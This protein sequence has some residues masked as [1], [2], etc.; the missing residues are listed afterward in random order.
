VL[1]GGTPNGTPVASFTRAVFITGVCLTAGTGVALFAVPGRT[2]DYWA[3]TIKAPLSAAFFGAGYVGAA[4]AL[5]LAAGTRE[6]RRARIVT[7][8]AFTLTSLALLDTL[9]ETGPFAFGAG[10]VTEAV[11]WIWLVVYVV[12]PPLLLVAFVRQELAGG[13]REYGL[14]HPALAVSRVVLGVAGAVVAAIGVALLADSSR[15][16]GRWP[17]ALPTLPATVIGAWFCTVASGLLWFALRER[18]WSRARIG[19]VPIC[20]ALILDLLAP[21]R[22]PEGL[23]GDASASVYLVGLALLLVTIATVAVVEERRL[24]RG[25]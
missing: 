11:A 14:E 7:V 2:G 5:A 23:A 9:R 15:L 19:I 12:L 18:D 25:S 16:T 24:G 22:L 4:V 17:W 13:A 21:A 10:G 6:W 8:L 1:G 3:W 20:L